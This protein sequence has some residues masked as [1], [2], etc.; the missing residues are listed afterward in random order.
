MWTIS[1][2]AHWYKLQFRPTTLYRNIIFIWDQNCSFFAKVAINGGLTKLN[3]T[4]PVC[5]QCLSFLSPSFISL[6]FFSHIFFGSDWIEWQPDE[7]RRIRILDLLESV[8]KSTLRKSVS[9]ASASAAVTSTRSPKCSA[10]SLPANEE[11]GRALRLHHSRQQSHSLRNLSSPT[12]N[13][14]QKPIHQLD[15]DAKIHPDDTFTRWVVAFVLQNT[16]FLNTW[17]SKI[18]KVEQ[19]RAPSGHSIGAQC[20][21][22]GINFTIG[23]KAIGILLKSV[24]KKNTLQIFDKILLA[25]QT[26]DQGSFCTSSALSKTWNW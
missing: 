25:K 16:L 14:S 6:M 15:Y 20:N 22:C 11:T 13:G 19:R 12:N 2:V 18:G 3:W 17:P 26:T 8:R 10:S 5:L 9:S 23:F 24:L 4:G 1:Y 21:G 7:K